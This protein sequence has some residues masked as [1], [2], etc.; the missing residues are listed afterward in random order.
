VITK[1]DNDTVKITSDVNT[2]ELVT[3]MKG[4]GM[5][6]KVRHGITVAVV[7]MNIVIEDCLLTIPDGVVMTITDGFEPVGN[8]HIRVIPPI[9]TGNEGE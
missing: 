6:N 5:W 8:I 4:S 2:A 9:N 3:G 1:I 7:H